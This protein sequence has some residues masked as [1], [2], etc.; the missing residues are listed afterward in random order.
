MLKSGKELNDIA[1]QDEVLFNSIKFRVT[2]QLI[3]IL[4]GCRIFKFVQIFR[5]YKSFDVLYRKRQKSAKEL[6]S[7]FILMLIFVMMYGML[8]VELYANKIQF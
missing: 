3:L 4:K 7:F 5:L 8:G 2:Q 1:L 6:Y